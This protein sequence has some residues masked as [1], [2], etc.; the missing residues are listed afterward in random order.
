MF[1]MTISRSFKALLL[2]G[3]VFC[4]AVTALAQSPIV[5]PPPVS[6]ADQAAIVQV[7]SKTALRDGTFVG[8]GYDAYWG[9]VQVQANIQNGQIVSVDALKSPNHNRTSKSI[10]R[11]ALPMLLRQVV[12]KQSARVNMI[13]GAT[14]TSRAYIASLRDALKQASN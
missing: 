12:K 2:C 9:I 5:P 11:Q 13:S 8:R 1:Q 3:A 4:G 7:A 6:G 10:N 14:L